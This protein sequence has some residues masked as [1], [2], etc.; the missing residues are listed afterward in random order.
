MYCKCGRFRSRSDDH[1]GV[2]EGVRVFEALDDG[3]DGALLLAD[4]HVDAF[5]ARGF[6]VDD[7]VDDD[8][9]LARL[10]VADDELALAASDG[11]HG[12]NGLDAGLHRLTDRLAVMTPGA[13]FS[14]GERP[15]A[16]NGT[17]AVDGLAQRVDDAAQQALADGHVEHA[18]CRLDGVAFGQVAPAAQHDGADE[19]LLEV[20]RAARWC[21]RA[22]RAP[23]PG[24]PSKGPR[25]GRCRQRC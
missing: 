22:G 17:L 24:G 7:G 5:H 15:E 14:M 25:C 20:E 9:R 21:R 3:G 18:A 8:G 6:L 1:D 12:V 2:L 11:N 19:V 4:G 23:R 10:A 13:I 16:C